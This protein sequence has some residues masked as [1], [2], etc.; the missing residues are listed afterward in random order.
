MAKGIEYS[1]DVN[2]L[3]RKF[4][5]EEKFILASQFQKAADSIALNIAEGS[6]GQSKA[7]FNR[8]LTIALRSAI[9]CVCCLHLGRKRSIVS[10][11]DFNEHY[12]KMEE[13]IR[14]ISGLK[15]S[16]KI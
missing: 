3:I 15:N 16:L 6:R 2:E 7:E 5:S 14:M 12:Q 13:I 1:L 10:K 9:E 4:P 11:E 8:F